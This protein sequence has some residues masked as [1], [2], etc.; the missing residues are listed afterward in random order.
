MT[1]MTETALAEG[2]TFVVKFGAAG[3]L[4]FVRCTGN[5]EAWSKSFGQKGM[6]RK[7]KIVRRCI[8]TNALVATMSGLE[9]T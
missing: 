1:K 4:K 3:K 5:R 6:R 2:V 8:R 7:V 9:P